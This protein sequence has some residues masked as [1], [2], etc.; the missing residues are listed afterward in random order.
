MKKKNI[1]IFVDNIHSFLIPSD[2]TVTTLQKII[3]EKVKCKI[4]QNNNTIIDNNHKTINDYNI[5]NNTNLTT[6]IEIF[7]GRK[8]TKAQRKAKK[9]VKKQTRKAKKE[10]KKEAKADRKSD[11]KERKEKKKDDRQERK[12]EKKADR[13]ADRKER[14]EKKKA[15]RKERKKTAKKDRKADRKERKEKKKKDRTERKITKK[16]KIDKLKELKSDMFDKIKHDKNISVEDVRNEMTSRKNIILGKDFDDIKKEIIKERK[17]ISNENN[18][19]Y[20]PLIYLLSFILLTLSLIISYSYGNLTIFWITC[21]LSIVILI[22]FIGTYFS[23]LFWIFYVISFILFII[24]LTSG[25]IPFF[26]HIYSC[27]FHY[28]LINIIEKYS[29]VKSKKILLTFTKIITFIINSL[30]I[31]LYV[32]FAVM[33]L[34][35][36]FYYS[37]NHDYCNSLL[38]SY[39]VGYYTMII[40]MIIYIL[41]NY[42]DSAINGIIWI[43]TNIIFPIFNKIESLFTKNNNKNLS[44]LLSFFFVVPLTS[45]KNS[46]DTYKFFPVYMTPFIGSPLKLIHDIFDTNIENTSEFLRFIET[47]KCS[48][49]EVLHIASQYE[50]NKANEFLSPKLIDILQKLK[51]DKLSIS[52][53]IIK[54]FFCQSTYLILLYRKICKDYIGSKNNVSNSMKTGSV[55]G[56]ISFIVF[57]VLFIYTWIFKQ[58]DK[59]KFD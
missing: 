37:Y 52:D 41:F 56:I 12:S 18:I 43:F 27:I 10:V 39:T 54:K 58:W 33:L 11:R 21:I 15:D 40:F 28:T 14:K 6:I 2:I 59:Y 35:F 55:S 31:I 7:G 51:S 47:H 25:I 19:G 36:P 1:N 48:V 38:A 29:N 24:I 32:W 4:L 53:K 8:K 49:D 30:S 26:S 23:T 44:S 16:Y 45:L 9:E 42:I 34:L 22:N 13:K 5:Q 17:D 20:S 46:I 3:S 50:K 57:I